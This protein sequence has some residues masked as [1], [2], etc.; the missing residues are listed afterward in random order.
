MATRNKHAFAN[1]LKSFTTASGKTGPFHS[2]PALERAGVDKMARVPV[3][4]RV[5]LEPALRNCDGKKVTTEHVKQLAT[6]QA[7]APRTHEIPFIEGDYRRSQRQVRKIGLDRVEEVE[8][9]RMGH[10][11]GAGRVCCE[12]EHGAPVQRV[13]SKRKPGPGVPPHRKHDPHGNPGSW[14]PTRCAHALLRRSAALCSGDQVGRL[15]ADLPS[16]GSGRSAAGSRSRG[17]RH[18]RPRRRGRRC[19][20]GAHF[21]IASWSAGMGARAIRRSRWQS[22]VSPI[23]RPPPRATAIP[24]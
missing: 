21:A 2:L 6:W 9:Q 10:L 15:Q 5:V 23:K 7:N 12:R 4:I 18:R 22:N 11:G 14:L 20:P 17:R 3:S 8:P 1:T 24:P 13:V 16:A 19:T